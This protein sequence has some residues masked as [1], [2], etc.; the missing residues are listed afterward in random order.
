MKNLKPKTKT[1][2]RKIVTKRFKVTATGKILRRTPEMRHLR[3]NK[4]KRQIRR[5]RHYIEVTG[6][7]A[8]K[9]RRMLGL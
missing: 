1:K 2:T 5:Y 7:M 8:K 9:I 6:V 3:K 4:S